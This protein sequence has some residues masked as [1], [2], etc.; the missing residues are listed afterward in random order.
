MLGSGGAEA[1]ALVR[2]LDAGGRRRLW[3]LQLFLEANSP[4]AALE[5]AESLERFI[6]AGIVGAMPAATAI[7]PEAA[8]PPCAAEPPA[9]FPP[10]S[11]AADSSGVAVAA[12]AAIGIASLHALPANI[13]RHSPAAISRS[14]RRAC[15][16]RPSLR[17]Y[18]M[19]LRQHSVDEEHERELA[20]QEEFLR[21]KPKPSPTLDDVV[22]FLR[23]R[24]DVVVRSNGNFSVNYSCML[25]PEQLIGRA[26]RKRQDLGLSAFAEVAG[27]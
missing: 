5:K 21:C 11:C 9:I 15:A 26:N 22:R 2:D 23:Q 24:G 8:S 18:P 6:G 17:A 4:D 16:R 1:L 20:M 14:L 3:L 19:I 25:T 12:P 13:D 27:L 7:A 10:P